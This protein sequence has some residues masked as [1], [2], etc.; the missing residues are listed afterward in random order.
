MQGDDK[1]KRLTNAPQ[2]PFLT[3]CIVLLLYSCTSTW[4]GFMWGP[5]KLAKSSDSSLK[6][7]RIPRFNYLL[8]TNNKTYKPLVSIKRIL[9]S[10]F[11]LKI[12]IFRFIVLFAVKILQFVD[13]AAQKRSARPSHK[14]RPSTLFPQCCRFVSNITLNSVVSEHFIQLVCLATSKFQRVDDMC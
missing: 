8:K 2:S 7:V 9:L 14:T 1:A 6:S 10:Y 5:G 3:T 4:P 11:L 12:L 13:S